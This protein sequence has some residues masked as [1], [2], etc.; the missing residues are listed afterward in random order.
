[1]SGQANPSLS[2]S[3]IT[4]V[5]GKELQWLGWGKAYSMVLCFFKHDSSLYVC[6][7]MHEVDQLLYVLGECGSYYFKN[8]MVRIKD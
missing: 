7:T 1:M 2:S 4:A 8:M 3:Y 6:K 5:D